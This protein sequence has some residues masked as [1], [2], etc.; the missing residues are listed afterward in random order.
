[1]KK[2]LSLFMVLMLSF[3]LVGCN[4]EDNKIEDN[5]NVEDKEVVDTEKEDVKEDVKEEVKVPTITI[6]RLYGDINSKYKGGHLNSLRL[7]EDGTSSYSHCGKEAGCHEVRG[8][9]KIE[10]TKLTV[11]STKYWDYGEWVKLPKTDVDV[12]T[13]TGDN[14]FNNGK[15]EYVLVEG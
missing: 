11:T 14:T 13:I 15:E 1:M 5:S 7:N 4:S 8:T 9:Y 12:F 10:G 6:G 2:F 3:V